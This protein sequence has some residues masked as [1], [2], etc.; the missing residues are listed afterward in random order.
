MP[1][2]VSIWGPILAAGVGG[3]LSNKSSASSTPTLDPRLASLQDLVQ[4]IVMQRLRSGSLPPAYEA[5]GIKGINAGYEG[6]TTS[7][8]ADLTARG[9]AASPVAGAAVGKLQTRRAGDIGNFETSLPLVQRQLQSEDLAGAR[10]L[11][12]AGRG[13]SSTE[14][15]GGG[16]AGA[17]EN[18]A[19][20][21][22]YMSR[23]GMFQRGGTDP[24]AGVP[25][26]FGTVATGY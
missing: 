8:N 9:L 2:G 22:G 25:G 7:L 23:K 16:A 1:Y 20:M 15:S 18:L 10:N 12:A 17:F 3:A 26:G 19:A 5:S 13:I 24:Y 11:L 21:L 14:S 6:A 4:Q